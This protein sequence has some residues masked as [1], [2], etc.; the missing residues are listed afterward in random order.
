MWPAIGHTA[1]QWQGH[2][3]CPVYQP[4]FLFRARAL[5]GPRRGLLH[6]I[7]NRILAQPWAV[8]VWGRGSHNAISRLA[9]WLRDGGEPR[10]AAS[11]ARSRGALCR[12]RQTARWTGAGLGLGGSQ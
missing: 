12:E 4:L 6:Q 8:G 5:Q 9:I 11:A 7:P 3:S 1:S 10:P 2:A